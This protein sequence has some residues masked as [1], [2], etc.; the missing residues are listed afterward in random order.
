MRIRAWGV[1]AATRVVPLRA[2]VPCVLALE[3]SETNHPYVAT[4]TVSRFTQSVL[5][6]VIRRNLCF[7]SDVYSDEVPC[8][9]SVFDA[10]HASTFAW[11][12]YGRHISEVDGMWA[13][14]NIA[15]GNV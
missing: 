3:Q 4:E 11:S 12:D 5:V 10:E 2:Q 6:N 13:W 9:A 14:L 1:T 7:G 8:F 15:S